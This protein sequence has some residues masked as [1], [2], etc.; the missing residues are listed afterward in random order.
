MLPKLLQATLPQ[1]VP[2][3]APCQALISNLELIL[4]LRP[5]QLLR[6]WANLASISG[7]ITL[8]T[9][10][11]LVSR[12]PPGKR[13]LYA[14]SFP[15]SK[16]YAHKRL[17]QGKTKAGMGRLVG[18]ERMEA[19]GIQKASGGAYADTQPGTTRGQ[20]GGYPPPNF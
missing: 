2:C 8:R 10:L 20:P 5:P 19:E 3:Q 6:Q 12:P 11:T 16:L 17:L 4:V 1:P 9:L 7:T 14:T 13:P 15:L 18:N